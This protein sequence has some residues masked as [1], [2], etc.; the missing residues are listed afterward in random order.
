MKTALKLMTL[1][2]LLSVSFIGSAWSAE[3]E[4]DLPASTTASLGQGGTDCSAIAQNTV[5][6]P[7]DAAQTP[8]SDSGVKVEDKGTP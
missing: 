4:S 7:A 6:V 1:V 8:G 5:E 3:D 2:T